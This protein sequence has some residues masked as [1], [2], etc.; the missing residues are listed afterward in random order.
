[1]LPQRKTS[2]ISSISIHN[3]ESSKV[4]LSL[5]TGE[6]L[7]EIRTFVQGMGFRLLDLR[8]TN[9]HPDRLI[10]FALFKAS[11]VSIGDCARVTLAVRDFIFSLTEDDNIRVEVSSPGAERILKTA[12]DYELFVN[13]KVQLTLKNGDVHK[14]LYVRMDESGNAVFKRLPPG[15]ES[16]WFVSMTDIGRCRL[17]L[18]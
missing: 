8:E 12:D 2:S 3:P 6:L 5:K 15:E 10:R 11:G 1:M 17:I 18:E 14:L 9:H 13:R 16:E 4:S 7:E